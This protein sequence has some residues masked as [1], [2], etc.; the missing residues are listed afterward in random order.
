[1]VSQS[2]RRIVPINGW[3]SRVSDIPTLSV[4][5]TRNFVLEC[6]R[7]IFVNEKTLL[8]LKDSTVYPVNLLVDGETVSKQVMSPPLAQTSI[9]SIV[10]NVG[11]DHISI[12]STVG[13]SVLVKAARV[14]EVVEANEVEQPT[15]R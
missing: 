5:P 10:R 12:G 2:S 7:D 8:V 4:D 11:N 3:T 13:P 9:P 6:S 15:A 14:E 1:M